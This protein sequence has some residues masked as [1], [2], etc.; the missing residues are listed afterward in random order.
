MTETIRVKWLDGM[1]FEANVN[2]YRILIDADPEFGGQKRGPKP[3]PLML[4]ALAGCTGMDVVSLLKKMRVE[5]K[6]LDII[7]EG[8]TADEHPKKFLEVKVIYELTGTNID[9]DKV[10]KAVGLSQEKYCGVTAS[11][12]ESIE[13]TYEIIIREE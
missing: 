4:V 11:L 8:N 1:A 13:L 5:Y 2:G 6:K 3:K 7:V 12:N 10:E 9:R